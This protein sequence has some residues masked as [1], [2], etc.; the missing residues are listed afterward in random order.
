M[1]RS[2]R[3]LLASRCPLCRCPF[4]SK[5][6]GM[7]YLT[8]A[9]ASGRPS[10]SDAALDVCRLRRHDRLDPSPARASIE[11]RWLWLLSSLIFGL[12]VIGAGGCS[13]DE[14]AL[15]KSAQE[16][17]DKD[18]HA[19][20]EIQIRNVLS[21][22]QESPIGRY[23]LAKIM[24]AKGDL[25]NAENELT[26]AAR[27]GHPEERVAPLMA[28]LL[29][30]QNRAKDVIERFHDKRLDDPRSAA[31]LHTQVARAYQSQR[32]TGRA[33]SILTEVLKQ[34]PDFTP[35]LVVKAR[36]AAA[37]GMIEAASTISQ[38]ITV[39]NPAYAPGWVLQGDILARAPDNE[40]AAVQAYRKALELRPRLT[41]AHSGL[42]TL[43]QRLGDKEAMQR[44]V[45]EM[46]K[47]LPGNPTTL[48]YEAV[49]AYDQGNY[50]QA[51]E[52]LQFLLRR[53]GDQLELLYL[54]GL[55]E[56][57]LDAFSFAENLFSRA[58]AV[59]PQAIEPRRALAG[60]YVRMGQ[61][62]RA[63]SQIKILQA[64]NPDDARV[65]SLLGSLHARNG[66]F[67]AA[68]QA[69]ARAAG[70][71]PDDPSIRAAIG[72]TLL[73][74][75]QMEPGLRELQ[76]A[77]QLDAAGTDYDIEIVTLHMRRN[78]P[79]AAI[80][81]A[82]E[83]ARKQPQS[84]I[85]DHVRGRILQST[86]DTAG[87]TK[88]YESA[89][90]KDPRYLAAISSLA[91][92]DI[93]AGR[94]DAARKRYEAFLKL[95]PRSATALMAVA[96]VARR[97]GASRAESGEWIEK[98][99]GAKPSDVATWR[100]AI[101]FYQR[102]GNAAAA[103]S[104]A[105]RANGTI[106]ENPELLRLL[107][108][109]QLASGDTQQAITSLN[110]VVRLQPKSADAHILLGLAQLSV[111][112]VPAARTA[113]EAAEKLA[114]EWPAVLRA[115]ITLAI[116]GDKE[117]GKARAIAAKQQAAHPKQALGWQLEG[118]IEGGQRNW[119]A[120]IAAFQKAIDKESSTQIARQLHDSMM[121]AGQR[122]EADTLAQRWLELHA[123]DVEFLTYLSQLAI[124]QKNFV[125]AGDHLRAALMS[126]PNDPVLLNNLA[127]AQLQLKQPEAL[128][129]A[130]RAVKLAPYHPA[131]LDTLAQALAAH[132][133]LDKA[134]ETQALAVELKPESSIMRLN[135]AR[136]YIA[137]KKNDKAKEQLHMLTHSRTPMAE[138]DAA[139]K[140][141]SQ[142]PD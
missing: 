22:N 122:V 23:M 45:A 72:R 115:G 137:A 49:V 65:H 21:T 25:A 142:L 57:R 55:T 104:L 127:M 86:G 33:E 37:Q 131:L 75:G 20:A 98:A 48:F 54:A 83:M 87:A 73:A 34:E 77:A 119:P 30:E 74:R 31:Q 46:S 110:H 3:V 112:N 17:L 5:L 141:L 80:K 84:A 102:D 69:F 121:Q 113:I 28:E 12:L 4:F 103:L 70:L 92:L 8:E 26:R 61:T 116:A 123:A 60:L 114:P 51:R 35:A 100:Q 139:E 89:V 85:P 53:A 120:A 136:Y 1:R 129:I 135:L 27:F 79:M 14:A 38:S 118:E 134:I 66:D 106:R 109:T 128:E 58:V 9:Y 132:S 7:S 6:S 130:Q 13:S 56:S 125:A 107:A 24:L 101:E 10:V 11:M 42:V 90:T 76:A 96:V 111:S 133:K 18:D 62:E 88:A 16:R 29:M 36:I 64:A 93:A 71:K 32:D 2:A 15:V 68:D 19:G 108:S 91:E 63:L 78:E 40:D 99:I 59:A 47:S 81:V 138:R 50:A 82:D 41:A 95:E 117:I 94:L 44:Q 43:Y 105:Q 67:R 52:R 97:S 124:R 39:K 126:R 140:L